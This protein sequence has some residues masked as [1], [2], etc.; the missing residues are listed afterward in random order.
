[1]ASASPS[2]RAIPWH[3]R[4]EVR[5]VA[6]LSLLVGLSL[7]AAL[8]ATSRVVTNRSLVQGLDRLD[9]AH[10]A[11]NALIKR[12]I[13]FA[14]AQTRLITVLPV[15]RAHIS[16]ARLVRDGA[17]LDAMVDDYRQQL[18]AQFCILTDRN[19]NWMSKPG[20]PP[21]ET[22]P[23]GL[24]STVEAAV[25]GRSQ[26]DILSIGRTLVLVVSEPALFANEVLGTLTVGYAL[27]DAIAQELAQ[28]TH[29]E[30]NLIA[31]DQLSGTS[32]TGTGRAELAG[33]LA[34]GKLQPQASQALDM[35]SIGGRRY[36]SGAFPLSPDRPSIG[37]DRMLLLQDW[38][39]TELFL[40]GLRRRFLRA[41][42]VI[43]LLACA[44]GTLFSRSVTRPFRDIAAAAG[45]I[46]N[47]NW[48]RQVPTRGSAESTTMAVAFNEMST[49][50]RHWHQ[51]AQNRAARLE[52]SYERFSSVTESARDAIISTDQEGVVAFWSRSAA[53]IFGYVEN[54][55]IGQSLTQFVARSDQDACLAALMSIGTDQVGAAFGRTIEVT[56][57]RKDGAQFPIEL[58]V[59][60]WQTGG[61]TQFTAV[62]RDIT[63]RKRAEGALK[64]LN[65]EI[66][67]QRLRVFKATM[68]T[69]QDIVNNLLNGLQLV[70]IEA[71]G[72]LS[73][74]MQTL[75]D[76][77]IQEAAAKLKTLGDLETVK[78][79]EL[80]I[81]LGIEYPGGAS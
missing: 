46:A 65:D 8:V 15:F 28:V 32:M 60:V 1:M 43:F 52:A 59:S 72:Q 12:Q 61:A 10:S 22:P 47:G 73:A 14:A 71:E 34:A 36:L 66:Q 30:V 77:M 25:A 42:G 76:R 69:V 81:G 26:N 63:E 49:H 20:W 58:S 13:E 33:L 19:G 9:A 17:T 23:A 57:V 7:G 62:V 79:K 21:G 24:R 40:S 3:R 54:E 16:D 31:A 37:T 78:E 50:L 29:C 70:H 80:A 18:K 68:T 35:Q 44:A 39:P 5:V 55:A 67:L 2:A 4:M 11:F 51:E 56:G 48:T 53:T 41:G 38:E 75:F 74:E 27:D 45:D 64:L 6:G